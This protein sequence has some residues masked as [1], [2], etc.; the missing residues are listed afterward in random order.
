[1]CEREASRD[2]SVLRPPV[3]RV[4][5]SALMSIDEFRMARSVVR[6]TFSWDTTRSAL[7]ELGI[8][9]GDMRCQPCGVLHQQAGSGFVS[10]FALTLDAADMLH[11]VR[12]Y[13]ATHTFPADKHLYAVR[14]RVER[15]NRWFRLFPALA[16]PSGARLFHCT[17]H[18][19]CSGDA[20]C[21]VVAESFIVGA[22]DT[23]AAV[24]V[25]C[26]TQ[27]G[28]A[29]HK[30]TPIDAETDSPFPPLVEM[31]LRDLDPLFTFAAGVRSEQNTRDVAEDAH[32]QVA[33]KRGPGAHAFTWPPPGSNR[34]LAAL[35]GPLF[36]ANLV[37]AIAGFVVDTPIAR[38]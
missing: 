1:V 15:W 17:R 27:P 31:R 25:R 12:R 21:V 10:M 9:A 29:L 13:L 20:M 23:A 16:I 2:S 11:R 34:P 6:S 18:P 26:S 36:D 24:T 33:T 14:T 5:R 28:V 19:G 38:P 4:A 3:T 37:R 7:A 8:V 32:R 30:D 22:T 35:C